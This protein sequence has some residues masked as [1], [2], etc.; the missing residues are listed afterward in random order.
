MGT[1]TYLLQPE[2]FRRLEPRRMRPD[3]KRGPRDWTSG[4][5]SLAR[6]RRAH[7]AVLPHAASYVNINSRDDLNY[8]NYL[9]RDLPSTQKRISFVYVVDGEDEAR[10]PVR[11]RG[12]REAPSVDEVD[13]RRPT[14][15]ARR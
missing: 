9:V 6:A 11:W 5:A 15:R 2:I 1:G 7:A 10:R 4:S 12:T 8:A 13:R 3:P 14:R